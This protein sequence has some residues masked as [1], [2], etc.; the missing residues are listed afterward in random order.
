MRTSVETYRFPTGEMV[1]DLGFWAQG[2]GFWETYRFPTGEIVYRFPSISCLQSR[3]DSLIACSH[4]LT[5]LSV[6]RS[7]SGSI[8]IDRR[9]RRKERVLQGPSSIRC[10]PVHPQIEHE[11]PFYLK[12]DAA[13]YTPGAW[14]QFSSTS[15]NRN[16]ASINSQKS[17]HV[18]PAMD[19][20]H[21]RSGRLSIICLG[22]QTATSLRTFATLVTPSC[23]SADQRRLPLGT[24]TGS[25]LPKGTYAFAQV[26]PS[27]N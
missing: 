26:A 11:P 3:L 9:V 25:G 22:G 20:L 14:Y 1:Q 16:H 19:S 8:G 21:F 23:S 27:R 10:E 15:A 17:D 6:R 7:S 4:L 5:R 12:V 13:K 18:P 24:M 2:L